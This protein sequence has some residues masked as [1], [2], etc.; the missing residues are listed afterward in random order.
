MLTLKLTEDHDF[1]Q[2]YFFQDVESGLKAIIVIHNTKLGP[3]LGGCR[4]WEYVS[5]EDA[6]VDAIRLARGMTYKCAISGLPYGGGKAVV[7]GHPSKGNHR[8]IFRALGRFI[9]SLQGRYIT[10]IDLGTTVA[11]MDMVKI[12]TSYVTDISGSLGAT[13]N[14]TAEMT[15]YGVFLSIQTSLK[16]VFGSNTLK[17][18]TVAVQGLGKVGY[19]LCR[20]LKR[21]GAQLIVSDIDSLRLEKVIKEF[22]AQSVQPDE[23]YKQTCDIFSPCA[24]GGILNDVTIPQLRCPIVAGAANNQ[25]AEPRHGE[26]LHELGILYAPDYVINAGGIIVTASELTDR[27]AAHARQNVRNIDQTLDQVF[28]Y[29]SSHNVSTS[30]AADLLTEQVLFT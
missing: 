12:E 10:G 5:E 9:D 3:S 25:L 22:E 29:S 20:Y 2:L 19:F 7:M 30:L 24:L 14:F 6:I 28:D 26:K 15:A 13:A 17:D 18:R 21:S 8:A 16:L 4:L 27:N 1:E 11:D 23:I